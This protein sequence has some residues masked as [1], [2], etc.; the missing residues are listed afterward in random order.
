MTGRSIFLILIVV[1]LATGCSGKIDPFAA[2][3]MGMKMYFRPT[4]TNQMPA[5]MK[6]EDRSP[7]TTMVRIQFGDPLDD[8]IESLI[9]TPPRGQAETISWDSIILDASRLDCRENNSAALDGLTEF[10]DLTLICDQTTVDNIRGAT[11]ITFSFKNGTRKQFTSWGRTISQ[12]LD[13]KPLEI[14]SFAF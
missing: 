8:I 5:Y 14:H 10:K 2:P 4:I 11:A 13:G 12:R 6:V 7:A 1:G 9:I 3:P